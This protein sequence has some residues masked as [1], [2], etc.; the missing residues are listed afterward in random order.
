MI[1]ITKAFV[2]LKKTPL[3]RTKQT[4]VIRIWKLRNVEISPP[5]INTACYT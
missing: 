4:T 5:L 1:N 2:M 3:A